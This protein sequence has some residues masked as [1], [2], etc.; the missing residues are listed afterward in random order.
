MA[1]KSVF[2]L[3]SLHSVALA[4]SWN[5][6]FLF[7][8]KQKLLEKGHFSDLSNEYKP[9]FRNEFVVKEMFLLTSAMVLIF[10]HEDDE[11]ILSCL[12]APL[13]SGLYFH[14]CEVLISSSDLNVFVS[15]VDLQIFEMTFFAQ[16]EIT[17]LQEKH[18]LS[19]AQQS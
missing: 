5:G 6:I 16:R 11:L 10:S 18:C 9:L 2:G 7:T 19:S 1:L 8:Q 3:D 17:V 12:P 15:V 4:R 13:L 14:V